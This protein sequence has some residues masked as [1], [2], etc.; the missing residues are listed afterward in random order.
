MKKY[1]ELM[2]NGNYKYLAGNFDCIG[3]SWI[4]IPSK[5]N[6]YARRFASNKCKWLDEVKD[7]GSSRYSY[8]LQYSSQKICEKQRVNRKG[9]SR[10]DFQQ[11]P[12]VMK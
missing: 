10:C 6:F 12:V 11:I 3:Q 4:K 9:I 2:E 5:A 1:L 8:Q 7:G